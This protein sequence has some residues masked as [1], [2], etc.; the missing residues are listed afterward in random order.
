MWRVV[1]SLAEYSFNVCFL[2]T[3]ILVA[4]RSSGASRFSLKRGDPYV[5]LKCISNCAQSCAYMAHRL[6]A[7]PEL[8]EGSVL[9][10][11][12]SPSV[13]CQRHGI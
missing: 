3:R 7:C 4:K 13:A 11:S 12:S 1:T 2:E 8:T 5:A 10:G 6:V 9:E